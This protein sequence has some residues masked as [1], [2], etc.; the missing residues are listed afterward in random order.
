MSTYKN[1][2]IE[3]IGAKSLPNRE[4]LLQKKNIEASFD[5]GIIFRTKWIIVR[6]CNFESEEETQINSYKRKIFEKRF[7][8]N[9]HEILMG[10]QQ[11][12]H[13]VHCPVTNYGGVGAMP[14]KKLFC[15]QADQW[16]VTIIPLERVKAPPPPPHPCLGSAIC[17]NFWRGPIDL[18]LW[19]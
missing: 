4:I 10:L 14:W 15:S 17:D 7:C 6:W 13:S 1:W 19:L 9:I 8:Y 3:L 18:G 12:V 2:A 11:G 16:S 5:M